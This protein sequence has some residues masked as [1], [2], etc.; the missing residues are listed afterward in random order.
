MVAV[1]VIVGGRG[2]L[3]GSGGSGVGVGRHADKIATIKMKVANVKTCWI[4]WLEG[5]C[6]HIVIVLRSLASVLNILGLTLRL[7]YPAE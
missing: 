4:F 1:G 3:V 2:V 5:F 7:A 6:I